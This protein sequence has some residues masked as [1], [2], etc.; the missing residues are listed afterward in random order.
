MTIKSEGQPALTEEIGEKKW[1][2][3]SFIVRDYQYGYERECTDY[4]F[5]GESKKGGRESVEGQ[6]ER[7]VHLSLK[8]A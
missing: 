1:T 7:V 3:P 2:I 8:V 6:L 5:G 4:L